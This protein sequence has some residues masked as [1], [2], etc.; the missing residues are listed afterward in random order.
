MNDEE[1]GGG[2]ITFSAFLLIAFAFMA[3]AGVESGAYPNPASWIVAGVIVTVGAIIGMFVGFYN[4]G[5]RRG[6]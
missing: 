5:R 4:L 1:R 6:R 2:R 3:G